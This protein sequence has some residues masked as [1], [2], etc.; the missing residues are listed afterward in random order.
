MSEIMPGGHGGDMKTLAARAGLAPDALLDFSANINPLGPPA[1]LRSVISR[2]V[3]A[4]AHYPDPYAE[5]LLSAAAKHFGVAAE[6]VVAGN[7][8]TELLYALP[9]LLDVDRVVLPAPCY[10]DYARACALAGV[11]T[12]TM[13][14]KVETSFLPDLDDLS[15]RCA[16]G[17]LVIL[18]QPNNPTGTALDPE[19]L[20]AFIRAHPQTHFVVDEAFADFCVPDVSLLPDLP[21]NAIVLRSLT[22]FYAIP[23]LRLGMAILPATV[24]ETVRRHMPPWSVNTLAQAVGV[25]ALADAEY[26]RRTQ[27]AVAAL[28]SELAESLQS[29]P[30]LSIQPGLA[31]Y[32]LVRLGQ[33][34]V[35]ARVLKDALLANHGIAIRVCDN[36]DGLDAGYFRVAVRMEK[37]NKRL[38]EALRG[39]LAPRTAASPRSHR[40]RTLMIQGT[41]SNA[42]KSVLTAAFCRIFLQDGYRVAPF[43]S[44]NMALNSYVT[45]GGG[46]MG[47]AQVTQAQACRLEPDVRM[48]PVLLKPSC[49]TGSQ[50]IVMGKP[51]GTMRV[52]EYTKFKPEA[53][54]TV[55]TAFDALASE[56]DILVMEGAGSPGE[57]NLKADDIVNMRMAA[58]ANAP[59]LLAGDIDRGGTYASFVGTMEVL[60]A[61]ERAQVAGYLVNKFRGDASLLDSA[62]RYVEDFTGKPV[63][64][65]IPH[66]PNLGL[67]EE[68]S[69][70]FK[71][72]FEPEVSRDDTRPIEIALTDLPYISNFT[73]ID[74][75]RIEP[76][77]SLRVV[78]SAEEFGSPDAV[79]LPGSKSV[80][81]DLRFLRDNGLADGIRRYV[82][83]K[84]GVVV[85]ICAGL[86]MLGARI[87][88]PGGVESTGAEVE[89]LGL[90]ALD[91]AFG[92]EKTLSRT[93]ARHRASGSEVSGYEIHHGKSVASDST[94]VILKREDGSPVG[95]AHQRLP[96]W[97]T[98]LHGIFDD[99]CFRRWF[100][101]ELRVRKGLAPLEYPGGVYGIDAA[102]DRLA[103]AVRSSVDMN[104]IYQILESR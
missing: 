93:R 9:G 7:G 47:R 14:L 56:F 61:W 64:G 20:R 29:L 24:A 92:E 38:I 49:D 79:I 5:P 36:Y 101:D 37:E 97:G 18:G 21:D 73:D 8:S 30:E 85:G 69:V 80:S 15:A 39:V 91:T 40:A 48:N 87:A 43:K 82:E 54:R 81:A 28:R 59:V 4:L 45:L 70:T 88:D 35:D 11:P 13:R 62:H 102:L 51:V 46:E 1:W 2:H 104:A 84:H 16:P 6:Y 99:D 60:D 19:T 58:Y 94:E 86:Q 74:P 23:G 96:V 52:R 57:V 3:E 26:A 17:T 53:F 71:N 34:K 78:R 32:L 12:E 76:D 66:L 44:Q 98:Y 103:D 65:V 63:L 42:G 68:D 27:E 22:K 55:K 89:G 33:G 41:C 50:V 67:P 31:N 90:L 77:V 95:Y 75:L 100:I 10:I 25:R 72:A 83:E